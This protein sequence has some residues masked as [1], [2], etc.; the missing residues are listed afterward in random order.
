[1]QKKYPLYCRKQQGQLLSYFS[2]AIFLLTASVVVFSIV[3]S[4]L[5]SSFYISAMAIAATLSA[6]SLVFTYRQ[7]SVENSRATQRIQEIDTQLTYILEGKF[8]EYQPDPMGNDQDGVFVKIQNIANQLASLDNTDFD[9]ILRAIK[10]GSKVNV[11]DDQSSMLYP[12]RSNFQ[13]LIDMCLSM[14]SSLRLL[15]QKIADEGLC[16]Q[17][18]GV[19]SAEDE[20]IAMIFKQGEVIENS[21]TSLLS[22]I[23][24]AYGEKKHFSKDGNKI[25]DLAE[26]VHG[27]V[28]DNQSFMQQLEISLDSLSHLS[29]ENIPET[30]KIHQA[31][32]DKYNKVL[33]QLNQTLNQDVLQLINN[34]KSGVF[35]KNTSCQN[36]IVTELNEMADMLNGF[37]DDTISVI[38]GFAKGDLTKIISTTY[39]GKFGQLKDVVNDSI[40]EISHVVSNIRESS[41]LIESGANEISLGVTD[42]N[43]RTEQQAFSLDQTSNSMI[44]MTDSVKGSSKNANE[45]NDMTVVAEQ[46]AV[47][48]GTAVDNAISA[49]NG[50]NIASKKIADIIGVIDEI[51]FQTN[52][53]A[54]NAAVEAARAGEQG[55]GFAVVAG[56]VRTLA[57]RSADAAKEIKDLIQ[58]SV[59]RVDNGTNLVNESGVALK[60]IIESVKKVSVTISELAGAM[61]KQDV[62]IQQVN[63]EISQM[64]TMTQQNA[65]LVEESSAAAESLNEQAKRLNNAVEFFTLDDSPIKEKVAPPAS[66][67]KPNK[68]A[69]T[70]IRSPLDTNRAP[71]AKKLTDSKPVE[72][73]KRFES[74]QVSPSP[75]INEP[76]IASDMGDHLD[77]DWEE[78]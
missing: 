45:A 60:E 43:Q 75:V 65:A 52:L 66:K 21:N 40:G 50:I 58:D 7:K 53:L 62:G 20:L 47:A 59:S 35:N 12:F 9:E 68:V 5:S 13:G 54:L 33:S 6:L 27:Y 24:L 51:A 28:K 61:H 30:L 49:M 63:G 22:E 38:D 48:G 46:C 1:M 78:F 67:P 2:L 64:D 69:D 26:Y 41:Q 16:I 34:V 18:Q 8:S 70:T 72:Q 56:E 42:L 44:D 14:Q 10:D 3:S 19:T 74:A 77:D 55:R 39:P 71:I 15:A 37:L 76:P 11:G 25:Q 73:P 32:S 29:F 36:L 4:S 31:L 57:Q 23:E 17:H